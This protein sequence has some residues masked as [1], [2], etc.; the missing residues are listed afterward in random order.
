MTLGESYGLQL[1]ESKQN[2]RVNSFCLEE[3]TSKSTTFAVRGINLG[4]TNVTTLAEIDPNYQADC[5]PVYLFNKRF[6]M[7]MSVI[8]LLM[9]ILY[10][11][12]DVV[13]KSIIIEAEGYPNEESKSVL[14]CGNGKK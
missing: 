2:N 10:V 7:L 12:R 14:L 4:V 8:K 5:G 1:I 6:L 3:K 9:L 13:Y 11:Y